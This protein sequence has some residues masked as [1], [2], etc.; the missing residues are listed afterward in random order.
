M[1]AVG[2]FLVVMGITLFGFT[3]YEAILA[4]YRYD[5]SIGSYWDL[6]D[7]A[8]TLDQKAAYIDTLVGAFQQS[9]L[10]GTYDAW[11]LKTPNESYD[12]NIQA[13]NSLRERLG[14]IKTMDKK[15]F[16]YQTAVQQITQQEMG[17]AQ[18]MLTVLKNCWT[19]VNYPILW[20]V[21]LLF[22]ISFN[23]ALFFGGIILVGISD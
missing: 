3:I 8:S 9:G 23:L 13:L 12:K 19:K 21:Y 7:K 16:E 22:W 15:S 18:A 17:E 5:K 11:I 1:K 2:I 6:A 14:T 4:D 20:G 10:A